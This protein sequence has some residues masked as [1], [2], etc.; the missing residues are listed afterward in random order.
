MKN[1]L[2]R[3]EKPRPERVYREC[4]RTFLN[5]ICS[6]HVSSTTS[7]PKQRLGSSQSSLSFSRKES[8]GKIDFQ[9]WVLAA[10]AP[11]ETPSLVPSVLLFVKDRLPSYD[12]YVPLG[13]SVIPSAADY[14][15][16]WSGCQQ[17]GNLCWFLLFPSLCFQIYHAFSFLVWASASCVAFSHMTV[18]PLLSFYLWAQF[19]HFFHYSDFFQ[20]RRTGFS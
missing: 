5:L 17:E 7:L 4:W 12:I 9:E 8:A 15:A 1:P 10:L 14:V 2:S 13:I 16:R 20:T 18:L 19:L 6:M 11:E 3:A